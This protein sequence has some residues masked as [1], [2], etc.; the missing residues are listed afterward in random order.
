MPKVHALISKSIMIDSSSKSIL[1]QNECRLQTLIV[2]DGGFT[3]L[4]KSNVYM[5][6]IKRIKLQLNY[7]HEFYILIDYL[8]LIEYLSIEL[9]K[10]ILI[11]DPYH[12]ENFP[13][14]IKLKEFIFC[15]SEKMNYTYLELF[16]SQ[17]SNLEYLSLNLTSKECI[18]GYRLENLLSKLS[19]LINFSFCIENHVTTRYIETYQTPY[20]LKNY[21][22][23]YFG[24]NDIVHYQS[25]INDNDILT[26]SKR[27]KMKEFY[28]LDDKPFTLE[29]FQ[30]I[31]QIC[32]KTTKLIIHSSA[33]YTRLNDD[34]MN[35]NDFVL[36]NVVYL[37]LLICKVECKYLKRLLLMTP[38]VQRLDML[39]YLSTLILNLEVKY[40]LQL[41]SIFN[42]IKYICIFKCPFNIVELPKEIQ[43]MFP[44]ANINK[45]YIKSN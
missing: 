39:W 43:L 37:K 41:Q 45:E 27:N 18:D 25:N 29:L 36:I 30:F 20:W 34:L 4:N 38:N 21:I 32:G 31:K 24:V 13:I 3:R 11:D 7:Q 42:R 9:C 40:Y 26:Y 14:L 44:N 33:T 2:E 16:I 12:Y 35:N 23:F 1:F 15:S 22:L 5:Y 19:K 28:I 6:Q 17:C 10:G 8:P